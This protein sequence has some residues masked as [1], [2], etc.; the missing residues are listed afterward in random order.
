MKRI[1]R[2]VPAAIALA[3]VA[4]MLV[5]CAPAYMTNGETRTYLGFTLGITSDPPPVLAFQAAPR[6]DVIEDSEVQII[7]CPDPNA[8]L[9]QYDGVCYLYRSGYWYR[10]DR[11]DG[12]YRAV[13]V[14][15]VP[16]AVLNVPA[17]HWRHR[18]HR[19]DDDRDHGRGHAYGHDHGD[20]H[21]GH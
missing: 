16:R 10:G 21:D 2:F 17:D 12:P 20:D 11:Y 4:V 3:A 14:H 15:R 1:V 6:M 18:P 9:F 19:D 13:D 5:S 7:E 8:D